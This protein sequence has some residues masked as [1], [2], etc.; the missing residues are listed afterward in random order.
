[1]IRLGYELFRW[2][3]L[4]VLVL[5]VFAPAVWTVWRCVLERAA[6]ADG[7]LFSGRQ[8]WL[9]GRT[10]G[11]A[12]CA[13]VV[14]LLL[15]VPVARALSRGVGR[16]RGSWLWALAICPLFLSPAALTFGWSRFFSWLGWRGG[17][18][19]LACVWSWAS[20][21][22]PIPAM[23][24]GA[25]WAGVGRRGYEAAL[26]EAGRWRAFVA[27]GLPALRG[28]LLGS[29]VILMGIFCADY[30]VPH[31]CSLQVY[32][33]ELLAWA[34]NYREPI[35]TLWASVPLVGVLAGSVA[36]GW[37]LWRG[38]ASRRQRVDHVGL[39]GAKGGWVGWSVC[40]VLVGAPLAGLMRSL[41]SWESF[42]TMGLVYGGELWA[43]LLLAGAGGLFG[44]GAGISAT[45]MG[46][47]SGVIGMALLIAGFVPG[48]LAGKALAFTYVGVGAIYD[49]WPI[50]VLAYV[51]RFGWIGVVAAWFFRVAGRDEIEAMARVDG[52]NEAELFWRVRMRTSWP[53]LMIAWVASAGFCLADL[54]TASLV[55]PPQYGLVSMILAEKFHR[56]EE[57]MLVSIS[58]MMQV[59]PIAAVVLARVVAGRGVGGEGR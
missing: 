5:A 13:T 7:W 26:L 28:H 29:A 23:L 2:T 53:V 15:S 16:V 49:H 32:S 4:G 14:S 10:M 1:M 35:H 34:N 24:L 22:W 47:A 38:S 55:A 45:C 46:R 8:M 52:A 59:L 3:G 48:A 25:G 11:L 57:Q 51:G 21:L 6:P 40:T 20:W 33:T 18:G 36:L 9:F 43:S 41:E 56:F 19:E 17:S 44:V 39:G 50:L 27:G 42:G 31:A 37:G 12:G 58:L 30:N 54:A